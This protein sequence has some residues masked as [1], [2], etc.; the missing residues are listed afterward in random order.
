MPSDWTADGMS[1]N[2]T[3]SFLD[4]LSGQNS[5]VYQGHDGVP[6]YG[7]NSLLV[8]ERD[9]E[10]FKPKKAAKIN[11]RIF[12][13]SSNDD[14]EE[15]KL[16]VSKVYSASMQNSARIVAIDRRFDPETKN[17]IIYLEWMEFYTYD[18]PVRVSPPVAL[19]VK[20]KKD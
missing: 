20:D 14:L 11:C 8:R 1:F 7:S 4:A 5:Q 3:S 15:Y 10:K 6:H 18:S 2:E 12:K 13:L 9:P 16:T 19:R 17:W